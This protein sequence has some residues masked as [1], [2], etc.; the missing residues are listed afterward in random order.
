MYK[1]WNRHINYRHCQLYWNAAAGSIHNYKK[2][3]YTHKYDKAANLAC[4][5]NIK[6]IAKLQM[7]T[8]GGD[9]GLQVCDNW[10]IIKSTLASD[11]DK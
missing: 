2:N 7:F 11:T 8:F 1:I 5:A 6:Y 4:L 10:Y 3:H 9:I